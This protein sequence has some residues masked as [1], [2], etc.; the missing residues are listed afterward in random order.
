MWFRGG[1]VLKAYSL[2]HHATLGLNVIKKKK[3]RRV[4]HKM[5]LIQIACGHKSNFK[6]RFDIVGKG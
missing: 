3:K 2:L 6:Y 4:D 1:L 5:L